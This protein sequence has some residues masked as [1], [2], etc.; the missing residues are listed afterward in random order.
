MLLSLS[1]LVSRHIEFFFFK[2]NSFFFE[3]IAFLED[4]ESI[5]SIGL[6]TFKN[7]YSLDW[8]EPIT[9]KESLDLNHSMNI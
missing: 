5:D 7:A 4:C 3:E 8:D 1:R 6:Q 2:A 9:A